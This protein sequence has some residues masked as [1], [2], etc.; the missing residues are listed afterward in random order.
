[1][2]EQSSFRD[3]RLLAVQS[4]NGSQGSQASQSSQESLQLVQSSPVAVLRKIFKFKNFLPGQEQAI[5]SIVQEN[6]FIVLMQIGGGKT[7]VYAVSAVVKSGII[8]VISPLLALIKD[9]V[10]K[11]LERGPAIVHF[12]PIAKLFSLL[13]AVFETMIKILMHF[14][15]HKESYQGKT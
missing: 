2:Q 4:E 3:Q 9:Q 10:Q 14:F 7:I 8:F 1:M 5:D 12:T 6:D 11:L 13:Q 15:S